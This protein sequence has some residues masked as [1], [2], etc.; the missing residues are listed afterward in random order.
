MS[1]ANQVLELEGKKDSD[2]RWP[3]KNVHVCREIGSLSTGEKLILR[4][5]ID[6]ARGKPRRKEMKNHDGPFKKKG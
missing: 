6:F 1:Q 2:Y 5:F 3:G 4:G